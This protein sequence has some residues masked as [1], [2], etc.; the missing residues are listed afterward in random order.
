[1]TDPIN[2]ELMRV[3]L[4]RQPR[5]F[6]FCVTVSAVPQYFEYWKNYC[7]SW[8]DGGDSAAGWQF[9]LWCVGQKDS[10]LKSINPGHYYDLDMLETGVGAEWPVNPLTEDEQITAYSAR[11]IFPSPIQISSRLDKM[12]TFEMDLYGNEEIM[13]VHQD[14]L[15]LAA[16]PVIEDNTGDWR[17][18]V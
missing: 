18:K 7:S 13:A 5:D 6:G 4:M 17:L 12:N 3:E 10:W 8:R 1:M 14:P 11:I 9:V 2:A 15:G 16:T